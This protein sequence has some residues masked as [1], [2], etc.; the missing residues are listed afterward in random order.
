[1][2]LPFFLGIYKKES[3]CLGDGDA[4]ANANIFIERLKT[5]CTSHGRSTKETQSQIRIWKCNSVWKQGRGMI[6]F[7]WIR[8]IN[9]KII[10]SLL[11]VWNFFWIFSFPKFST[12]FQIFWRFSSSDL[13]FFIII[14]F[15]L[16]FCF[17]P[18]HF[19]SSRTFLRPSFF[20][21]L[22]PS[23]DYRQTM[24]G[25]KVMYVL[26]NFFSTIRTQLS[27]QT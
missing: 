26:L 11:K 16:L 5:Q 1:M 8:I 12:F 14:S 4:R 3:S 18:I 6:S 15:I 20:L 17:C 25:A 13:Y 21:S 10:A 19:Q 7:R 24:G 22:F 2:I 23:L 27:F 9:K